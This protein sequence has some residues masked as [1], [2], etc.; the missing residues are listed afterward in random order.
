MTFGLDHQVGYRVDEG[1]LRT[2]SGDLLVA[3]D[4]LPRSFPHDLA[5][6]LAAS[7]T[8]LEGGASL[9]GVRHTL[10]TFAGLPHRLTRVG[11]WGGVTWYDDSKAT[12]PQATLAAVRSF[13]QVVLIAGGQ[14]KGTDLSVLAAVRDR[15]HAAVAIGD[16]AAEVADALAGTPVVTAT[17]MVDAVSAAADRAR[18][19]DVVLLSPAC[20]SFDWYSSYGERGDAFVAA[21]AALYGEGTA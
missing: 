19:G 9:E 8:A 10:R 21:V 3:V 16:A 12:T 14:N 7:A 18:P 15:V 1:E 13:P 20:A 17:S 4:E 11:E 6:A 2:D 5:N